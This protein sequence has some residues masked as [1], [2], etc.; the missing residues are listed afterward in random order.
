MRWPRKKNPEDGARRQR[1]AFAFFPTTIG[2]T[3]IWLE[4]YIIEERYWAVPYR[5]SGLGWSISR[6][7]QP[8]GWY[9]ERDILAS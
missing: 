9:H 4:H 2:D 5:D 1:S 7:G 8:P 3:V 6:E